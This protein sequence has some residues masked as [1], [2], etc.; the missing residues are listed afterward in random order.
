MRATAS[1]VACSAC[2]GADNATV[3]NVNY[4]PGAASG[5]TYPD[6]PGEHNIH[7]QRI[8]QKLG[9][10]FTNAITDAQQKTICS[11]C[12]TSV[13]GEYRVHRQDSQNCC[14]EWHP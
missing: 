5:S 2:H 11:F 14:Q 6:R 12:H 7:V 8:A 3:G 1:T 10:P 13:A 9:Y 4:W